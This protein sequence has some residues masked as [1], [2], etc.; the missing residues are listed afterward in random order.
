MEKTLQQ[1]EQAG[2]KFFTASDHIQ[3]RKVGP[4]EGIPTGDPDQAIGADDPHLGLI[5]R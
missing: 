1:A 5:P 2:V 4:G 3:V